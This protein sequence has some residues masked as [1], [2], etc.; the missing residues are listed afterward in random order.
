MCA[1]LKCLVSMSECTCGDMPQFCKVRLVILLQRKLHDYNLQIMQAIIYR[2]ISS[3]SYLW[4]YIMYT[5]KQ[6][7]PSQAF[8]KNSG[9]VGKSENTTSTIN[10][11][12]LHLC[13]KV[14]V[15]RK[16]CRW[17]ELIGTIKYQDCHATDVTERLL[18]IIRLFVSKK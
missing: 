4:K 1:H 15:E 13:S 11:F 2:A 5:I 14:S 18:K 9:Y 6:T 8:T 3:T 12:S 7:L 10:I 16:P 17:Q